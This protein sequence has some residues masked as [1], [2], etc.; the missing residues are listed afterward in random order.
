MD[1]A[2]SRGFE[3]DRDN[4][5]AEGRLHGLPFYF[6]LKSERRGKGRSMKLW[7]ALDSEQAPD[8]GLSDSGSQ[9]RFFLHG[10]TDV[11][12]GKLKRGRVSSVKY[13]STPECC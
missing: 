6:G 4:C 7:A 5:R 10:L 8:R 13:F 11:P 1:F 2:E 3:T 12:E 9:A